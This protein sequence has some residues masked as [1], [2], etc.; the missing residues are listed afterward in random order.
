MQ[1]AAQFI[2]LKNEKETSS[3]SKL[4]NRLFSV[5]CHTIKNRI[6]V[7]L[8]TRVLSL[9][10]QITL[11]SQAPSPLENVVLSVI[12]SPPIMCNR[13]SIVFPIIG[14]YFLSTIYINIIVNG[15][16][17]SVIGWGILRESIVIANQGP[18]QNQMWF[19]CTCFPALSA[20]CM[21]LLC[22]LCGSFVS[23]RC[24]AWQLLRSLNTDVFET[25][26]ATRRQHFACQKSSVSQIMKVIIINREK[27]IYLPI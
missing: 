14:E 26:T 7:N 5:F 6:V 20:G 19:A 15:D 22:V 8:I 1:S 9:S 27:E 2:S 10:S 23:L 13:S 17:R 25:R 21:Q 3:W 4:W 16:L 12:S 11:K 18:I 24:C